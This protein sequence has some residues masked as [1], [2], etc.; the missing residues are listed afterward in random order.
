MT[1]N[2]EEVINLLLAQVTRIEFRIKQRAM[3][4]KNDLFW[5]QGGC[6]PGLMI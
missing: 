2:E 4:L 5:S 3:F 1:E 6:I